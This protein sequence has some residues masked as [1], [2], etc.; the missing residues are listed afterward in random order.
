M[1]CDLAPPFSHHLLNR[2]TARREPQTSFRKGSERLNQGL[3]ESGEP[4]IGAG[5]GTEQP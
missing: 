4:H 5:R 2:S 3:S 1:R